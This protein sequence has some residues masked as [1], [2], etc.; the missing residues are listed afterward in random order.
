[1]KNKEI[2]YT[3]TQGRAYKSSSF[4]LKTAQ[5]KANLAKNI[6]IIV[7]KKQFT[8]AVLRNGARRRVKGVLTKLG[9]KFS[10]D[11]YYVFVVN[12]NITTRTFQELI[13]EF[14]HF[15]SKNG[16]LRY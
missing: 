15:L 3:I 7:P 2:E 12:K 1:M 4:L 6:A 10:K 11:F 5:N 14:E 16:I 13:I 8:T 9:V